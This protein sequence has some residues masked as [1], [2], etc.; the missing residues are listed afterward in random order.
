V[1]RSDGALF[2]IEN[3]ESSNF[4]L[5]TY[6]TGIPGKENEGLCFDQKA[7]RLL[8]APKY[9]IGKDSEIKNKRFIYSFDLLSK[10]LLGKPAFI[11]DLSVIDKFVLENKIDVPM[12]SSKKGH[13]KEPDIKFRPSAIGIHPLTNKLFVLSGM[14][15]LLFVFN[16]NGMIEYVEKLDSDLFN[17][18]EGITFMKNGDLLISNE[19][20]QNK[21][22][23]VRFTA[24][25]N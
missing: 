20:K 9:N 1:L 18:P 19:G 5:L 25:R 15:K 21:P 24:I 4:K 6:M 2:E 12:K 16:M 17:Q 11:I 13:K 3:Y 14:E 7:N 22:T 8:I 10:K 23:I